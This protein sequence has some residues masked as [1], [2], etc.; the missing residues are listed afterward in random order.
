MAFSKPKAS[1]TARG[2]GNDHAKARKA[3]L[4]AYQ[5]TDPC[6]LCGRS[7]GTNT[8]GIH[9]DHHPHGGYRGLAHA[10]CNVKDGARRGRA[11]QDSTRLRW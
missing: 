11:R 9:L 6:C 4:A 5:P 1:T 7:L 10:R 2:Y 3:A 8:R